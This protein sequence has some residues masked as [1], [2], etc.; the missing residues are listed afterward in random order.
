M[1]PFGETAGWRRRLGLSEERCVCDGVGVSRGQGWMEQKAE[2]Q[3]RRQE[4][5]GLLLSGRETPQGR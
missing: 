5:R 4:A 2:Q 1:C 3:M